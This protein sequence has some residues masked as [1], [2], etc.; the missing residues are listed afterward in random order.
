M[1]A[2]STDY[3]SGSSGAARAAL[4]LPNLPGRRSLPE[5]PHR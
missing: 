3:A 1:C 5:L 2:C 4:G